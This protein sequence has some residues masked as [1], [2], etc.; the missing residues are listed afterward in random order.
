MS[1]K[2]TEKKQ[3]SFSSILVFCFM[4]VFLCAIVFNLYSQ[5]KTIY[6]LKQEEIVLNTQIE[7][8]KAKNTE[9]NVNQNYYNSDAYIEKVAREQLGLIKPGE[10]EFINTSK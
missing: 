3:K 2:K 6:K 7:T 9:L 10:I 4:L 5:T 8:E 1:I